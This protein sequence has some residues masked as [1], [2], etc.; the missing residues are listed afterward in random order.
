MASTMGNTLTSGSCDG[1]HYGE[2]LNFRELTGSA[3]GKT[4]SER[5]ELT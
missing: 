2:H 5:D 1:L 3:V 4:A